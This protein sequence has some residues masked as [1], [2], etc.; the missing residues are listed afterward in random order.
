MVTNNK[1]QVEQL[2][3]GVVDKVVDRL[4]GQL[5]KIQEENQER[6]RRTSWKGSEMGHA[7]EPHA[8]VPKTPP[9]GL[10]AVRIRQSQRAF[11]TRKVVMDLLNSIHDD[12]AG[13]GD[14]NALH[15]FMAIRDHC[16]CL[17]DTF[18]SER[19]VTA[20]AS[21]QYDEEVENSTLPKLRKLLS[22]KAAKKLDELVAMVERRD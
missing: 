11:D 7:G 20:E 5:P 9:N 14:L 2:R 13:R 8:V 1:Q 15:T 6:L 10:A 18:T 21:Y 4:L 17:L 22:P 12:D 19:Y 16:I 3:D